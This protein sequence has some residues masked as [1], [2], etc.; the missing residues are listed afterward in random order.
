MA[1]NLDQPLPT[2]VAK[3]LPLAGDLRMRAWPEEP[4]PHGL[5]ERS[6][7]QSSIWLVAGPAVLVLALLML[8][9]AYAGAFDIAQWAPPALFIL[10]VLLTL[11]LRGGAQRLPDRW[12]ALALA[13]AW[14]LAGWAALSATWAASPGAALEGAG[15][16]AM[17]AAVLTLPLV[18]IGDRR[19]LRVA[20]QGIVAGIAL[21]ALYTLARMLSDGPALFLAGRLNGPVEYR[22]A[23]ALLFCLAYWPLIVLAATRGRGRALRA[24]CLGLAE[25]MLGLAFL[26]QS[27]G[28]LLGLGCGAVVVLAL[29]PDQVRRAWLAL[30]SAVLLAAAA[31]WLLAPYHA[32][33]TAPGVVSAA[34]ISTAA[35]ALAALVAVGIAVGFLLAVFDTGLRATSP[36]MARVRSG[37]RVALVAVLIAG[38]AGGLAAVH[39]NPAH[40]LRV[41]WSQFKSLQTTSTSA[42]RYTSAGG[43]RYDLWRVALNELQAH[44]LGGVGEGSYQ[45]D[46]YLQRR[47]N[48]NLD[49]PH[50]LLFQLGGE[51]GGV[52][53]VLFALIPLGL[54]GSL[55]RWWRLAALGVRREVCGLTAAGATFIG[56]SLVDWMWRIPGLTALGVLCLGVAAA[57]L[58][59]AGMAREADGQVLR[60]D[61]QVPRAQTPRPRA[62]LGLLPGSLSRA[63]PGSLPRLLPRLAAAAVLLGAVALTASLYLSD[64]YIRR[65]RDEIG[66]SPSAQLADARSAAGLDPWSVDPHYLEASALESMGERSAA[67]AQLQDAQRMEP[68]NGVPLGLLGDFEAR[69]GDYA[70]ARVYYRRALRLDPLDTG[71]QQLASTGGRPSG[72]S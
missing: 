3:S 52:G 44:P 53:L 19:A 6:Q 67:R 28:V 7:Q 37:A 9:T 32:F 15:Q 5:H 13:G 48:R 21:I 49:D 33:T 63:A 16:L 58:A 59:R 45:F 61:G 34:D 11:V 46:Y 64:F 57:L 41:K 55:C 60:A 40:E 10:I 30:L 24:V 56:Q 23:T 35:R 51:L 2:D 14:G 65:A 69:G 12:L 70:R 66:H 1:T 8:A 47:T 22:N 18:A 68:T 50:G 26:T 54:V 72:S 39:G 38:L 31:P 25:L 20:A 42:T 43:Q 27:R 62:A 29:G 71:L 36:A 4:P 17:Y